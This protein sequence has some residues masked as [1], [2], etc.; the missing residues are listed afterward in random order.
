MRSIQ[1]RFGFSLQV[2]QEYSPH[3]T[4]LCVLQFPVSWQSRS[5]CNLSQCVLGPQIRG[6]LT[7]VLYLSSLSLFL[8]RDLLG[9]HVMIALFHLLGCKTGRKTF[10]FRLNLST[11]ES[12]FQT[13]VSHGSLG[14]V[15]AGCKF[16]SFGEANAF[17][18]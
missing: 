10:D 7:F 9:D 5:F 6:C 8:F 13:L 15:C 14:F 18:Q 4:G 3:E 11:S 2:Y 12:F 17:N 16:D 1:P